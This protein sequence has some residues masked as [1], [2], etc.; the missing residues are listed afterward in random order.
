V[1]QHLIGPKH[2]VEN[3]ENSFNAYSYYSSKVSS[4]QQKKDDTAEFFRRL[5]LITSE[6]IQLLAEEMNSNYFHNV[7]ATQRICAHP[8]NPYDSPNIELNNG[9]TFAGHGRKYHCHL[10]TCLGCGVTRCGRPRKKIQQLIKA[11]NQLKQEIKL[12]LSDNL[13]H[14]PIPAWGA[15]TLTG[16][17]VK[18]FSLLQTESVYKKAFSLLYARRFWNRSIATWVRA[19]EF[20]LEPQSQSDIDFYGELPFDVAGYNVHFHLLLYG[21]LKTI[22]H[23]IKAAWSACLKKAWSKLGHDLDIRTRDGRA[24]VFFRKIPSS[25]AAVER[26]GNYITKP[27]LSI[28]YLPDKDLIELTGLSK[29]HRRIE[30]GRIVR[31]DKKKVEGASILDITNTIPA[32]SPNQSDLDSGQFHAHDS[33]STTNKYLP[34]DKPIIKAR[35]KGYLDRDLL[36]DEYLDRLLEKVSRHWQYREWMLAYKYPNSVFRSS[37]GYCWSGI[38][39]LKSVN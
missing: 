2:Y 29:G 19:L 22:E 5:D 37:D 15:V 32:P 4:K 33:A 23:D 28:P 1:F 12:A 9:F 18:G 3:L 7:S 21:D 25:G 34:K 27:Q 17:S 26:Y 35:V 20:T 30:I 13:N 24:I 16:P 31:A 39:L 36:P 11:T 8:R 10:P 38:N 6:R 14:I